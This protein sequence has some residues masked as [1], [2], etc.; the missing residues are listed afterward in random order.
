MMNKLILAGSMLCFALAAT[1]QSPATPTQT[2]AK[3]TPAHNAVNDAY[4]R[5]VKEAEMNGTP[6]PE[7]PKKPSKPRRDASKPGA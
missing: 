5:A 2:Q 6:M 7:K 1:A 4:K 3:R